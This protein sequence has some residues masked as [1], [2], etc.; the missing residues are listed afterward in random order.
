[1]TLIVSTLKLIGAL[2]FFTAGV[3]AWFEVGPTTPMF[4][5]NTILFMC[6]ASILAL[7][8]HMDL[9]DGND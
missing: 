7:S 1:M 3:M 4:A 5:T 8:G 2:V 6:A 9:Q